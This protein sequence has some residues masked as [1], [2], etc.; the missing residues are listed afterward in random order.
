LP[1]VKQHII[2]MS[3]NASRVCDT[4]RVLRIS[5]DTVLREL[6]KKETALESVNS[7]CLRTVNPD[8]M[9]VNFEQAGAAEL[10]EMWSFVGKKGNQHWLWDAIAHQTGAVSAYVFGRRQAVVCLQCK[11]LLEP[12]RH[13][14][15]ST[16]HWGA[17]TRHSALTGTAQANATLKRSSASI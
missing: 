12:G 13:T 5:T 7:A 6:K 9:I 4:A 14:R 8:K 17:Y 3:L 16:A 1:E 2:D 11:A 15:F 10:D